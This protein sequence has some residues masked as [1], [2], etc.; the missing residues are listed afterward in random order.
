LP[1]LLSLLEAAT[2]RLLDFLACVTSIDKLP[3]VAAE[4]RALEAARNTAYDVPWSHAVLRVLELTDYCKLPRHR[5]GWIAARLGITE[6]AVS[7]RAKA[8]GLRAEEAAI[9]ALAAVLD[10]LNRR[11]GPVLD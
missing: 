8:A 4:F 7:L 3:T 5:P 2:F 11:P 10:A 1:E 6:T 9:P